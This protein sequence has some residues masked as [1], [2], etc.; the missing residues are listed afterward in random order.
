MI[1]YKGK[2]DNVRYY[3]LLCVYLC[4]DY[5]NCCKLHHT[6]CNSIRHGNFCH[7]YMRSAPSLSEEC[8]FGKSDFPCLI[9]TAFLTTTDSSRLKFD[10][11]TCA[12]I[13]LTVL[14][15]QEY[16]LKNSRVVN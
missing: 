7:S 3:G 11:R 12:T 4:T 2:N 5:V 14:R 13:P 10:S 16:Y 9:F 15:E 1:E 6:D 8:Q